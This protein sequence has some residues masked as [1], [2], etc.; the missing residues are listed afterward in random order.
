M[1]ITEATFPESLVHADSSRPVP[2]RILG[3]SQLQL[4]VNSRTTSTEQKRHKSV[5][6]REKERRN[7]NCDL[8]VPT[9]LHQIGCS[10]R[11]VSGSGQS[12]LPNL[13]NANRFVFSMVGRK[14]LAV[15]RPARE[16]QPGRQDLR[17][18]TAQPKDHCPCSQSR[19]RQQLELSDQLGKQ[20]WNP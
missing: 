18:L 8:P 19:Q 2:G 14:K 4:P 20:P 15:R 11:S 12:E 13:V 3:I 17:G 6:M 16:C 1:A 9:T 10:R 7:K 5:Y